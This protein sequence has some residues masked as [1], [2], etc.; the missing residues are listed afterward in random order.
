MPFGTVMAAEPPSLAVVFAVFA[1]SWLVA[2]GVRRYAARLGL[3]QAPNARSAHHQPTPQGGG[4]GIVAGGLL[5]VLWLQPGG[6]TLWL[7]AALALLI[8]AV[9]LRDD[10]RHL[11][12]WL[13]LSAQTVA[14]MLLLAALG[15]MPAIELPFGG[16]LE[17]RWLDLVLLLAGV[18]WVNLFNFMDGIDGLAGSQAAGMLLAAAGLAYLMAPDAIAE[19][20][21]QWMLLVAVASLGFLVH[22]WPPARLFMGD[23]G[24]T[25]LGFMLFYFALASIRAGWVGYAAW[26]ILAAVF[27]GDAT[28]TLLARAWRR[29]PLTQAHRSHAY[30]RLARRW[31]GH[32]PVLALIVAYNST[33]LL[34]CAWAALFFPRTTW[35]WVG[36][37]YLP[38]VAAIA[39]IGARSSQRPDPPA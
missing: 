4:L 26:M 34:P 8:A 33:I 16:R 25:F 7:P 14:C 2:A 35:L 23:V 38:V 18:W 9:G 17:G 15:G 31:G 13:R 10:L 24:S 39:W 11:P 29:E 27:V 32:L 5:A 22:N 30:Q 37:A 3:V 19:P 21:W 1:L 6:G 12:P 28:L 36:L 20:L